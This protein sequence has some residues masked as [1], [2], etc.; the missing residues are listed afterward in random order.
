MAARFTHIA[1]PCR[2]IEATLAWY[3]THTP[4]RAVHRRSDEVGEVAW[5]AEETSSTTLVLIQ[6]FAAREAGKP[7]PTLPHSPISGSPSRTRPRW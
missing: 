6:S 1:L 7:L 5:L 3:E 4:M 2:D